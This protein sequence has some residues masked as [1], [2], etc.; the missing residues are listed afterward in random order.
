MPRDETPRLPDFLIIGAAKAGTTSLHYYLSQHPQVSMS[1]PKETNFFTRDDYVDALD[2]YMSCFP[3]EP[4]VRGEASPHYSNFPHHRDVPERIAA[5]MP[6]VKLIYLVRDPIERAESH[7][8]HKYFNRTESRSIDDA[9]AQV[10]C[11]HVYITSSKYGMQLE[12]YLEYFPM[13][14]IMMVDNRD[15]KHARESTMRSV[16]SFLDV[17]PSFDS[18]AFSREIKD[19]KKT[20]RMSRTAERLHRSPPVQIARRSLPV[21]FREPLFATARRVLSPTGHVA[22]AR[23]SGETRDRVAAFFVEDAARLRALTGLPLAHWSV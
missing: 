18:A 13:S 11:G 2:W 7:Y 5:L 20:V 6:D 14:Q 1:S 15:L 19:R 21:R 9:F 23:L 12:R 10:D 22:P 16:F 8:F 4:G 3:G 17:D